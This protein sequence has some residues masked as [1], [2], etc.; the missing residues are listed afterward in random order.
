MKKILGTILVAVAFAAVSTVDAKQMRRASMSEPTRTDLKNMVDSS[1][2]LLDPSVPAGEKK[3]IATGLLGDL[4]AAGLTDYAAL[5][6]KRKKIANELEAAKAERDT[7]KTG[8]FFNS[9]EWNEA[10]KSVMAKNT[11]LRDVNKE[12]RS[13]EAGQPKE[14]SNTAKLVVAG[15]IATIGA[16]A[17]FEYY[18]RGE[19]SM[20]R[21][22]GIYTGKKMSEAGTYIGEKGRAAGRYTRDTYK[23]YAPTRLGGTPIV[24]Q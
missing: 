6:I 10:N 1:K 11:E 8:W 9:S 15:V 23:K 14:Q 20:V 21:G 7:F 4:E 13:M 22:A 17:A 2:D 16:L 18:Y 12:I 3:Q 24:T 19:A 5:L